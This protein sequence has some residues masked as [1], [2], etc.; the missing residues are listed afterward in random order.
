MKTNNRKN[1]KPF[2]LYMPDV[3]FHELKDICKKQN[4]TMKKYVLKALITRM[5]MERKENSKIKECC[6][7]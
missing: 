5:N 6:L 3:L 2:M 4:S 1:Q 7:K